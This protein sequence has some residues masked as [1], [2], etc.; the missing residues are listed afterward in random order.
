[1]DVLSFQLGSEE[2]KRTKQDV[3]DYFNAKDA[4]K[5]SKQLA[6]GVF[7]LRK[8][9]HSIMLVDEWYKVVLNRVDLFFG[10]LN[11]EVEDGKFIGHRH[12][13]S[14]FSVI[15]K[16]Y[17]TEILYLSNIDTKVLPR[18]ETDS[19]VINTSRIHDSQIPIK[20]NYFWRMK[21]VN[22]KLKN[23]ILKK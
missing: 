11:R 15:R 5:N 14:V 10:P 16:I 13:Q 22:I 12:D 9:D 4:I 8:C 6:S 19:V 7:I 21:Y 20:R 2:I 3:F 23:Y 1:M 18:S 17:G